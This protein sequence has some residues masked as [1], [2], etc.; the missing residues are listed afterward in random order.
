MYKLTSSINSFRERISSFGLEPI[1]ENLSDISDNRDISSSTEV[2]F[3]HLSTGVKIDIFYVIKKSNKYIWYSYGKK[4]D[5]KPN[6]RCE[7][8]VKPF[9]II[10]MEFLNNKYLSVDKEFLLDHYG[11]DW[12][13]PKKF[14]Y[15]DG[16]EN[17]HYKSLQK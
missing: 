14:G 6:K 5:N 2:A 15:N 11:D 10:E 8:N 4:C 12:K 3:K 16:I 17:G 9:K 7:F 13:T 1:L